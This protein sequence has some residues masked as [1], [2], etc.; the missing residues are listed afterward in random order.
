MGLLAGVYFFRYSSVWC[1]RMKQVLE[2]R[3]YR[4][5]S[6]VEPVRDWLKALA[7][8]VRK[9]VGSNIQLVQ[10]QWPLGKPLVDGFGDG[11]FEVRSSFKGNIYRVFFCVDKG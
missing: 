9:E 2:C 8:D 11:L 1:S 5:L 3:F 4:S 7:P 6:G 10:W